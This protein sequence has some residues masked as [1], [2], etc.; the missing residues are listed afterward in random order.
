MSVSYL[1]MAIIHH[2]IV[3]DYTRKVKV[4]KICPPKTNSVYCK[5]E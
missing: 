4:T 2:W 1:F 3:F 5:I